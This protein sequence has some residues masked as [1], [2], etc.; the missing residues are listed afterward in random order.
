MTIT[1]KEL[2]LEA[3]QKV[4]NSVGQVLITS[5]NAKLGIKGPIEIFFKQ[6]ARNSEIE[7]VSQQ[8]LQQQEDPLLIKTWAKIDNILKH[9]GIESISSHLN[10]L[11]N[12]QNS[13]DQVKRS[14]DL[15]DQILGKLVSIIHTNAQKYVNIIQNYQPLP[16]QKT[17]LNYD[18]QYEAVE[19]KLMIPQ[20]T[21]KSLRLYG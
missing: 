16:D 17:D 2:V 11:A 4:F 20:L 7:Q 21:R 3:P 15:N 14:L 1:G 12:S 18:Q 5:N 9:L 19:L 10:D 8:E 13:A 6:S